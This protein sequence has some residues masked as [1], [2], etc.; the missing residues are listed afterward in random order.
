MVSEDLTIRV[1]QCC[2]D[3]IPPGLLPLVLKMNEDRIDS[4]L[5][6]AAETACATHGS[7]AEIVLAEKTR[8][9][10]VKYKI[11]ACC[12]ELIAQVLKRCRQT[13]DGDSRG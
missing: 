9:G 1:T 7:C 3:S 6:E 5:G 12:N 2:L 8:D 13:D 10:Q 4:S 11:R